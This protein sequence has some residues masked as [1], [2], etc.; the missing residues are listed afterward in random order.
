MGL[1]ADVCVAGG[2][3]GCEPGTGGFTRTDGVP[4]RLWLRHPALLVDAAGLQ[5][6]RGGGTCHAR[7]VKPNTTERVWANEPKS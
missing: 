6:L 3:F 4:A 5:W 1:D 2:Q 7:E